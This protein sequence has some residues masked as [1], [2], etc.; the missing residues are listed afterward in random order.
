MNHN[1][2]NSKTT[3]LQDGRSIQFDIKRNSDRLSFGQIIDLWRTDQPFRLFFIDLL[4]QSPFKAYKWETPAITQATLDRP[5]EFVMLN[6]PGLARRPNPRAFESH[7][8]EM[9]S[10]QVVAFSNLG[11][12]ALMVVPTPLEM[13]IDYCHLGAFCR[14][15]PVSHQH[16]LWQRVGEAMQARV[17]DKPVWLSTAGGGVPWLHVRL[18]DR[19][20][21]YGH[22]PYRAFN[23]TLL[24]H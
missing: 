10:E 12:D 18:D 5:F 24:D 19:P 9:P 21:Y 3:T 14:N 7:F 11:G 4:V 1:L 8:E 16:L 15:A 13:T 17:S 20:K 6:S 22:G 2:W 23:P